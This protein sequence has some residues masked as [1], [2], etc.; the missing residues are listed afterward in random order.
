MINVRIRNRA[1][2]RIEGEVS[3]LPLSA[4]PSHSKFVYGS[5]K[6]FFAYIDNAGKTYAVAADGTETDITRQLDGADAP[7]ATGVKYQMNT[8]NGGF[9][10]LVNDKTN[11]P[12]AI[13]TVGA[14][15][16]TDNLEQIPGWEYDPN[17]TNVST[18][19][20]RPFKNVLVAGDIKQTLVSD[21]T[22]QTLRWLNPY[23]KPSS[24]RLIAY[25]GS[26]S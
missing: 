3:V 20:I 22:E 10:L 23:L 4:T 11:T 2:S 15:A 21:G 7:L 19:I 14:A 26:T 5:S 18:G 16:D 9:V 6:Q 13:T 24:P 17:Y 8:V 25:L 12:E 1:V